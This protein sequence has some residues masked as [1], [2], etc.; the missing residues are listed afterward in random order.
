MVIFYV[1]QENIISINMES[2][3][4]TVSDQFLSVTIDSGAIGRK[5]NHV[6]LKSRKVINM[7]KALSPA[8]LRIGG[9]AEDFVIFKNS[10]EISTTTHSQSSVDKR[11]HHSNISLLASQLDAINQFTR[12][13]GWEIIFGLN[14]F[15]RTSWPK[16]SWDTTNAEELMRYTISKEY[17]VN[18]ELGNGMYFIDHVIKI[19]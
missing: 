3:L 12:K 16:G 10:P 9:T 1:L 19:R 7:A 14:L 11:M 6:D 15:L 18:W 2:P 4:R 13:V 5:W 8:M 17:N